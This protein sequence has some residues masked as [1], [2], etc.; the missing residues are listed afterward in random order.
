MQFSVGNKVMHP[1]FGAGE[2]TGEEHRELVKGFRHYFVIK[3]LATQGTAYVPVRKMIELGVRPVMS[4]VKLSQVLDTLRSVP[5]WLSKDFK[6]R[7][8][9]V[10]EMLETGHPLPIAEA[11]RDL[12]Y[13]GRSRHLTQKDEKLLKRGRE[14]L[15]TEMALAANLQVVDAEEAIDAALEVAMASEFDDFGRAQKIH[16]PLDATS[17]TLV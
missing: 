3:I 5:R 15:A 7:Q 1:K 4:G 8:A 11:I 13:H 10:Q 9:W 2:I 6:E 12:T 17:A 16:T 14:L